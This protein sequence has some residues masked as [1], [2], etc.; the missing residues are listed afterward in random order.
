MARKPIAPG[1]NGRRNSAIASW[2]VRAG[3][4]GRSRS[5]GVVGMVLLR[6]E[7]CGQA[8]SAAGG[9][10]RPA[11]A[12]KREGPPVARPPRTWQR[13]EHE[14]VLG[15]GGGDVEQPPLLVE[16]LGVGG[17]ERAP[18]RQQL[19]LA[20]RAARRAAA[21]VPLARWMVET[22]MRRSSPGRISSACRPAACSRKPVSEAPEPCSSAKAWAARHSERRS[23]STRSPSRRSLGLRRAVAALLVV[24]DEAAVER[25]G[26]DDDV[27]ERAPGAVLRA[28]APRGRRR[29]RRAAS[30]A[31]CERISV[32][33]V[34]VGAGGDQVA[35]V[36][37]ARGG[38][39]AC[40][41]W[42]CRCRAAAPGRRAGTPAR[43]PG[44]PAARG[45]RAR[46]GPRRARRGRGSRARGAGSRPRPA[47]PG[48]GRCAKPV[49]A[50]T[51]TSPGG[52]PA[53]S[54]SAISPAT[55]A[56]SSR[57]ARSRAW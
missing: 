26:G 55:Q 30:R 32:E 23:S 11:S 19:L 28:H 22:V 42:R 49:R 51:S 52:V 17:F 3:G 39:D 43:R 8:A 34:R 2:W 16:V 18:G 10:S 1:A 44:W 15:A 36:A 12:R 47:R 5:V 29:T 9:A 6:V 53:A 27:P 46:R 21:S 13:G 54:A 35:A 38:D 48:S 7:G 31:G 37:L 33:L 24:G 20:G 57:S 50:S 56:A 41:R 14:V 25:D 45:R 4:A 40:S